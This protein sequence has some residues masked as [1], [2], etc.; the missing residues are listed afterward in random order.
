[1]GFQCVTVLTCLEEDIFIGPNDQYFDKNCEQDNIHE[2][3]GF[4]LGISCY[5]SR[6][7][8]ILNGHIFI[9]PAVPTHG[10]KLHTDIQYG[11]NE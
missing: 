6:N 11:R 9:I 8:Y 5:L 1:M 7:K 2:W 10:V 4:F 3:T